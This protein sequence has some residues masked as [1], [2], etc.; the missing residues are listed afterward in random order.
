M[1]LGRIGVTSVIPLDSH[2]CASFQRNSHGMISLTK[3]VGVGGPLALGSE[4]FAI[5]T[6]RAM[7]NVA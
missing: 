4:P 2:R 3:K 7:I 6:D 1:R 5:T